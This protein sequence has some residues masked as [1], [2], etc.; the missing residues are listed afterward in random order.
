M[1]EKP[2]KWVDDR[3]VQVPGPD[4]APIEFEL[5]AADPVKVLAFSKRLSLI[6]DVTSTFARAKQAFESGQVDYEGATE[7]LK[8]LYVEWDAASREQLQV[9]SEVG[10]FFRPVGIERLFGSFVDAMT[11]FAAEAIAHQKDAKRAAKAPPVDAPA[12]PLKAEAEPK[13]ETPVA[14]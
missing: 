11:E 14:A 3:K 12:E 2:W 10:M 13:E 7:R 8:K 5:M 6:N 1:S 4:D 9:A